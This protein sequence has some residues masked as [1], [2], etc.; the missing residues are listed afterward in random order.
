M[1]Y[2]KVEIDP[3]ISDIVPDLSDIYQRW[4]S[5]IQNH[6]ASFST[7]EGIAEFAVQNILKDDNFLFAHSNL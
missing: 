3:K 6:H 1:T 5:P 4:L 2:S 7:M